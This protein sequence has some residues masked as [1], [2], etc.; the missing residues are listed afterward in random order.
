MRLFRRVCFVSL[1]A[2]AATA[3][4]VLGAELEPS[5]SRY[6][7]SP[8][9]GGVEVSGD[10]VLDFVEDCDERTLE[11][12]TR[13]SLLFP[14]AARATRVETYIRQSESSDGVLAFF[15]EERL[16]DGS[17][18]RRRRGVLRRVDG[19]GLRM[20][21]EGRA[22]QDLPGDVISEIAFNDRVFAR[23][24]LG[25]VEAIEGWYRVFDPTRQDHEF[26]W[27]RILLR[28]ADAGRVALLAETEGRV[29]DKGVVFGERSLG[30]V[31]HFEYLS[32]LPEEETVPLGQSVSR[33]DG[34]G[35]I[36]VELLRWGEVMAL[37]VLDEYE[38][39][40]SPEC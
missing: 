40:P 17:P 25:G 16:D 9:G 11:V 28:G 39:L 1:L 2:V 29:A 33:I 27:V 4:P 21:E 24:A 10:I 14:G 15:Y 5:H 37:A 6:V 13:V 30:D 35:V 7:L 22:P 19:G 34:E 12:M 36:L 20:E 18:P 8:A 26:P 32:F 38:D 23:F 31:Y 3:A